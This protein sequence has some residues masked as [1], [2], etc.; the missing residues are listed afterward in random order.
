MNRPFGQNHA[1]C[2]F[3][4]SGVVGAPTVT[5]ETSTASADVQQMQSG[6]RSWEMRTC[7]SSG[8]T[9]RMVFAPGSSRVESRVGGALGGGAG[10]F[11]GGGLLAAPGV[12]GAD[13]VP[14]LQEHA[15]SAEAAMNLAMPEARDR[16]L[17]APWPVF[18]SKRPCSNRTWRRRQSCLVRLS[19]E[20]LARPRWI[21]RRHRSALRPSS[22]SLVLP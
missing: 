21:S 15:K 5:S 17:A 11:V 10:W 8:E 4:P 2:E 9:A 6:R 13:R 16:T 3:T 7:R 19:D 12:V 14:P 22:R 1:K 18:I 20:L